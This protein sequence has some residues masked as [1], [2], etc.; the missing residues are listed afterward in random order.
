V[1]QVAAGAL[2]PGLTLSRTGLITGYV[3]PLEPIGAIP[4]FDRYGFD[5]YPFD[6][7]KNSASTNFAFTIEITDG[8]S[9]NLRD[10]SIFNWARESFTADTTYITA[11]NTFLTADISTQQPPIILNAEPDL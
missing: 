1:V 9:S 11:D 10:F 7:P 4:G 8:K 6:F 5:R 3:A 2:P